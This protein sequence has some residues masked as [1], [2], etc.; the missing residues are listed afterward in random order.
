MT[1]ATVATKI[2]QPLDVSGHHATQITLDLIMAVDDIANET[3][4]R[5]RQ[6]IRTGVGIHP[7]FLQNILGR[8][9]ANAVN[10]SKRNLDPLVSR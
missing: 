4:F 5:F 3:G 8:G 7:G 9:A 1:Q 2:H 6:I 10:I